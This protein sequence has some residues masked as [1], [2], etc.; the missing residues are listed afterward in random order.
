MIKAGTSAPKASSKGGKGKKTAPKAESPTTK[1][2]QLDA[3]LRR[4]EG[5]TIAQLSTALDWQPHSVRG[6]MSGSLKKKRGLKIADEKVEGKE[7]VY[8]IVP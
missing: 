5:A 6:A 8:R 1:L 7:R 3:L 2:S 4:P